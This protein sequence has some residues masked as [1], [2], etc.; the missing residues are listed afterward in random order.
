MSEVSPMIQAQQTFLDAISIRATGN[1]SVELAASRARITCEDI[2]AP[3][4]MP[5]YPRAIVEGYFARTEDTAGASDERPVSLTIIG[6]VKPGDEACPNLKKGEVIEVAT[7]SLVK[8]GEFSIVRA[9]EAERD[10]TV[11]KVKRKFPPGFFIE[12]PGC[13][14]QVGQTIVPA[15]TQLGPKE[16][17]IL[18]SFGITK[19]AV[20]RQPIVAVFS[21][22]DEVV[23]Y[24][25]QA[26]AGQIRDCNG[27]MLC[28]AIEEVGGMARFIGIMGDDFDRFVAAVSRE[29]P[30]VDAIVISGGTAVGG[31][32]F[33]SN[34][35]RYLGKICVDGVPM[36]SGRPLI[37]G[38]IGNK[39][40]ICLAGHPPEAL[41]GFKLF[42]APAL[43]KLLG[44]SI[45]LP[46]DGQ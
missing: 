38:V 27:I 7:G 22:G 36:K 46:A 1:E 12:E 29:L 42:G 28:A 2:V 26:R 32:D 5:P 25:Q 37:M 44:R 14:I 45:A 17:G 8:W 18:A 11:I 23:P 19:V 4:A 21:S 10:G 39:P 30:K 34:L 33:I 13:D 31:A 20:A 3:H 43:A 9:W 16:I 35:I 40:I 15:G 24:T 41:R 6:R